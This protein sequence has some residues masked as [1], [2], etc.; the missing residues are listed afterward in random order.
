MFGVIYFS[1]TFTFIAYQYIGPI[2]KFQILTTKTQGTKMWVNKC[3]MGIK[4]TIS[5]LNNA[6]MLQKVRKVSNIYP[7]FQI[8]NK[9]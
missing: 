7:V 5:I 1:T 8:Y 2:G 3:K 4:E 9:S 6:A